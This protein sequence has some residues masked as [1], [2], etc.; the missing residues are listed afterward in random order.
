MVGIRSWRRGLASGWCARV[1]KAATWSVLHSAPCRALPPGVGG[2]GGG[3]GGAPRGGAPP[4]AA[5]DAHAPGGVGLR[6]AV[7]MT[8]RQQRGL[9]T[10]RQITAL[11]GAREPGG[12]G[13][14]GEVI[15]DDVA[16]ALRAAG[17]CCS[18]RGCACATPGPAL[19]ALFVD[20]SVHKLSGMRARDKGRPEAPRRAVPPDQ[21]QT[22]SSSA[23]SSPPFTPLSAYPC[24]KLHKSLSIGLSQNE[25]SILVTRQSPPS[26]DIPHLT[27]PSL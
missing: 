13:P 9:M 10:R 20:E 7:L 1:T 6:D 24:F 25:H 27:A 21:T 8:W 11:A 22:Q 12:A 19:E 15:D 14:G 4:A 5:A 17:V 3:G 26:L 18:I 2:E 23:L 16:P